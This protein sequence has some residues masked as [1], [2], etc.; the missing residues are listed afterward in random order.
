MVV[1]LSEFMRYSLWLSEEMVSTL[2]KDLYHA[3]LYLDIEKVR[4]GNK[5][6][7]EKDI[8]DEALGSR[9]PAM[10]LQPLLE[11]AVKH[12]VYEATSQIV[13]KLRARKEN[14]NLE[15]VIGN[16]IDPE[17]KPRKGTGTGLKNVEAR[18]TSHYGQGR[19]MTIEKSE[20]YFEVTLKIPQ[21]V[22]E[23]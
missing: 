12:G 16:D 9:L 21:D 13:V 6:V 2:D 18:L 4:F 1:K 19:L 8:T 11:N 20:R 14:N 10:I 7:V 22:R 17:G 23:T 5:L 3:E 15:I